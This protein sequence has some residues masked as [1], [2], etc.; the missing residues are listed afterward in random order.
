METCIKFNHFKFNCINVWPYLNLIS[1]WNWTLLFLVNIQTFQILNAWVFSFFSKNVCFFK[2]RSLGL[3]VKWELGGHNSHLVK[4]KHLFGCVLRL[5]LF[6]CL[7]VFLQTWLR[8][9]HQIICH[10][11]A[12]LGEYCHTFLSQWHLGPI[13]YKKNFTT[14]FLLQPNNY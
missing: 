5:P 7:F 2:S 12:S 3:K 4:S 6:V 10:T 13:W 1:I 11:L 9:G 8:F 14:I